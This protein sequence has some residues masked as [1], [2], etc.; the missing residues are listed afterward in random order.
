ML[1]PLSTKKKEITLMQHYTL[2]ILL[3]FTTAI[4]T[5]VPQQYSWRY[6]RPGNTGIQGDY[7]TA[8]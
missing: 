5:I 4:S 8:L 7:A 6:Y 3:F 2:L 1:Y